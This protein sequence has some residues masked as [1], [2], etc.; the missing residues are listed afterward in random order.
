MSILLKEKINS[1]NNVRS[2]I[3]IISSRVLSEFS[4]FRFKIDSLQ[5]KFPGLPFIQN[6]KIDSCSVKTILSDF[7]GL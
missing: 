6:V 1:E 2:Q 3:S 4:N 5:F 7:K